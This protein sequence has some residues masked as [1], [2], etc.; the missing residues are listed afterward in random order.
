M[1]TPRFQV[2][3]IIMARKIVEEAYIINEDS[4]E[5]D[6]SK[7]DGECI[8]FRNVIIFLACSNNC[9]GVND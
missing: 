8:T 6:I 4:I 9:K 3:C 1:S 5:L 7:P 2:A